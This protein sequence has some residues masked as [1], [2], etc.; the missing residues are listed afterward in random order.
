MPTSGP[1]PERTSTPTSVPVPART[2]TP[3]SAPSPVPTSAPVT[4]R[5]SAP[6]SAPVPVSTSVPTLAPVPERTSVPTSAPVPARTPEPTS[7]PV[8]ARTPEPTSSPVLEVICGDGYCDGDAGET[9]RTCATDCK[10][11]YEVKMCGDN[12]CHAGND[13]NLKNCKKGPKPNQDCPAQLTGPI[14]YKFCCGGGKVRGIQC[15]CDHPV[16]TQEGR[17]CI[18]EKLRQVDCCKR[19][20]SESSCTLHNDSTCSFCEE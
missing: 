13:E 11:S 8:P 9:C 18:T 10:K 15:S 20:I 19:N 17:Q 3:I 12:I 16:C 7:A 14:P 6:T 4:E 5:T 2:S 1:V